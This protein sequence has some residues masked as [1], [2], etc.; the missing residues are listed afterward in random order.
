M[1]SL[2]LGRFPYE[3]KKGELWRYETLTA[4]FE[5]PILKTEQE[6]VAER[7]AAMN[8]VLKVYS[9]N[10][11]LRRD[12][13]DFLE[14]AKFGEL[15]YIKPQVDSIL[16]Q[17]YSVGVLSDYQH[18]DQDNQKT[19]IQIQSGKNLGRRPLS[20]VYTEGSARTKLY[21]GLS[22]LYPEVNVDSL[23]DAHDLYSLVKS[24]LSYDE[25]LTKQLRQQRTESI[26]S[27]IGVGRVGDVII[28][29]DALITDELENLLD[30]YKAEFNATVGYNGPL[31]YLWLGNII[32]SLFFVV[33]LFL[34]IYFCN[35]KVF[36][37]YNKYVFLLVVSILPTLMT[38]MIAGQEEGLSY[39]IPYTLIA[40]FLYSFFKPKLVLSV[41]AISL[42]PLLLFSPNG[43]E[44]YLMHLL[45]GMICMLVF[46]RFSKGWLQFV[47]A[48]IAFF[49]MVIVWLSFRMLDGMGNLHDYTVIFNMALGA[50]LLVA[51]YPLVYLFEKVFRLVSKSKLIEL[52]DTSNKLLRMLADKAPGTF[53]H[54]L[55][56]M[57][58]ADAAATAIDAD[59][60]LIR[61]GALYHDI[62][63]IANP[64]CFT[65]NSTT[66]SADYH[67]ELTPKESAQEIIKH[68]SDG[69]ALADKHNLPDVLKEFIQTHHGTTKTGYFYT[70]YLNDGGDPEDAEDFTYDGK[71][72]ETKEQVILML[73]DAVE[74]ASRSL[75]GYSPEN[76]SA[77][78]NRIVEGKIQEGQLADSNISLKEL[79]VIKDA[80]KSYLV[81]MYHS[82]V[83]YPKRKK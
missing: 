73:A 29:R 76:I 80:L 15:G 23:V 21:S 83:A 70:K 58:L 19:E 81:Q 14:R 6:L 45:A 27:T 30:S 22:A 9:L 48:L 47:S 26:S 39:L 17:I 5:F 74:A 82:R 33:A 60:P 20:E 38:V 7:N 46:E 72:P 57:N 79:N 61:A 42:L 35:Y 50:L 40:L 25:Q 3:Y 43:I 51:A 71:R 64:H 28:T 24:N 44:L 56:V 68:V 52:S 1:V 13:S 69:L 53:Q 41:Y 63:K 8:D 31:V 4:R 55:Q 67:A 59:V 11:D 32:V 36:Y 65:E 18:L 54:S 62:G 12:A 66:S 77:L 10:E 16:T 49:V 34:A 75:K 2:T 78:V 37:Q